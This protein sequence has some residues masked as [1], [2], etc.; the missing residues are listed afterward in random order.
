MPGDGPEGGSFI[1]H[2]RGA[3]IRPADSDGILAAS[4]DKIEARRVDDS[5]VYFHLTPENNPP[6]SRL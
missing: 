4:R 2:P 6:I 3:G 5:V 1:H